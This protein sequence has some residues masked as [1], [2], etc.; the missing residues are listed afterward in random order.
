MFGIANDILIA[1]FDADIR[2]YDVSLEQELQRFRQANLK[3]NKEKCLFRQIFIPFFGKVISKHWVRPDL[4]QV[5]APTN[6]LPPKT[7]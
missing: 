5:K 7:K 1:G 6:V 4:E 3:L 2:D